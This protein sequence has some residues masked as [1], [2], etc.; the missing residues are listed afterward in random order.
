MEDII[1]NI[2]LKQL[3]YD[4]KGLNTKIDFYLKFQ[5]EAVKLGIDNLVDFVNYI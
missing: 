1:E 3:E 5:A 2:T 4:I